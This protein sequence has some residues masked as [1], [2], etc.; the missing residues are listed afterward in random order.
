M[1]QSSMVSSK[2]GNARVRRLHFPSG[3][4]E[5]P[6]SPRCSAGFAKIEFVRI[7]S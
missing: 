7:G 4:S 1:R 5:L 6:Q 3:P 2:Y